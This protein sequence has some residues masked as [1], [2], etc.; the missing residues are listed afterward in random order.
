MGHCVLNETMK[1][2]ASVDGW[3][4]HDSFHNF[5]L[6]LMYTY[7]HATLNRQRI[8]AATQMTLLSFFLV[9]LAENIYSTTARVENWN[10]KY[11]IKSRAM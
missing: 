4:R 6:Y 7:S 8:V 11:K 10:H 5:V 9:L 1:I 3:L 2:K